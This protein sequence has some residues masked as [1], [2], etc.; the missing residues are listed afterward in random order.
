M[1]LINLPEHLE[2]D[3]CTLVDGSPFGPLWEYLTSEVLAERS[4]QHFG[5]RYCFV[6]HTHVP[7]IFQQLDPIANT[8][9]LPLGNTE[10][11]NAPSPQLNGIAN[12]SD[13]V[14]DTTDTM[15]AVHP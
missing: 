2:M 5:T 7:V 12:H 6:G 14:E 4:F 11:S 3:D 15:V 13:E 10:Q 1:F 8:P 9:T